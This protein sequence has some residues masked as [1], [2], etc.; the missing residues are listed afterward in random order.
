MRGF[1]RKGFFGRGRGRGNPPKVCTCPQC[2]YKEDYV[3]GTPCTE[4]KC[5]KCGTTMKGDFCL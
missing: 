5:P 3:R 4:K 2:G 1:F